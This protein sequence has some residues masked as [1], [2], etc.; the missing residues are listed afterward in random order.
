[1]KKLYFTNVCGRTYG[2]F[3]QDGSILLKDGN[4]V[5]ASNIEIFIK[6]V[7]R[8]GTTVEITE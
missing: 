2:E 3:Q 1:M 6:Y 7:T 4:V 8:N 5:P